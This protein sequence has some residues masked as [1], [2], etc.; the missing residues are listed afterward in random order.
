MKI[1]PL[2]DEFRAICSLTKSIFEQENGSRQY[3]GQLESRIREEQAANQQILDRCAWLESVVKEAEQARLQREPALTSLMESQ[4]ILHRDLTLARQKAEELE[5]R[6]ANQK[7]VNETLLCSVAPGDGD[8]LKALNIHHILLENQWQ[9]ELISTLQNTIQMQEKTVRG[10]QTA[11]DETYE[12]D[13]PSCPTCDIDGY[14][15]NVDWGIPSPKFL[16]E[17][18]EETLCEPD[19]V[20]RPSIKSLRN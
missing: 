3:Q 10:L 15:S 17:D 20:S 8:Q 6:I 9:C 7:L 16:D 19:T 1:P 11:L 12:G 4:R 14:Q 18:D 2:T 13:S 5:S